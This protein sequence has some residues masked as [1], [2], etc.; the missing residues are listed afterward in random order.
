MP[1]S[2]ALGVENRTTT[3]GARGARRLQ[4]TSSSSGGKQRFVVSGRIPLGSRT[5]VVWR[6]VEEPALYAGETLRRYLAL[7]GVR[8]TGKVRLGVA[9]PGA[10]LVH[11]SQSEPL[12]DVVREEGK[13]VPDLLVECTGPWP[14]YDFVRMQFGG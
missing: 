1:A 2:D 8:V 7:R 13:R 9:P 4:I 3:V 5:Q 14:P 11:V 12:S 10:R 6:R